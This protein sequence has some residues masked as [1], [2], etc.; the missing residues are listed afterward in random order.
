MDPFLR[1]RNT[2]PDRSTD[3]HPNKDPIVIIWL[4]YG[5]YDRGE[6]Y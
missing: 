3:L 6:R 1:R 4:Q 5:A 2:G